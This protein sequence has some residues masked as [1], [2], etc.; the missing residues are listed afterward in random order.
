MAEGEV[1][2]PPKVSKALQNAIHDDFL[3]QAQNDAKVTRV[4]LSAACRLQGTLQDG[5]TRQGTA[6]PSCAPPQF[7]AV[8]Q[9]ADYDTFKNMV[10]AAHLR[11]IND[12]KKATSEGPSRGWVL[13]PDGSR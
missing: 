6:F 8:A 5:P 1:K 4:A 9:F 11:P 10:A 3:K 2:R 12:G 13:G 7:R